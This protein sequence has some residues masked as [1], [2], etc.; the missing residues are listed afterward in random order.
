MRTLYE[1]LCSLLTKES[2]ARLVT[3]QSPENDF[4]C[5]YNF[6]RRVQI[7]EQVPRKE[8]INNSLDFQI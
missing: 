7:S 3:C 2:P 6:W 1:I 4:W 5:F 8:F